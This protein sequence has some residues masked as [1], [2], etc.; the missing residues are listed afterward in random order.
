VS[1]RPT[2]AAAQPGRGEPSIWRWFQDLHLGTK[3]FTVVLVFVFVFSV[4]LGLGMLSMVNLSAATDQAAA[5]QKNVLAPMQNVRVDQVVGQLILRRIAMAPNS[6][7]RDTILGSLTGI[8][9]ALN[10]DIATV[11]AN[12]KD[13]VAKWDQ[14]LAERERYIAYRDATLLPLAR[15]GNTAAVDAAI[16]SAPVMS[17]DARTTLITDAA[18]TIE[19]RINADSAA[20]ASHNA[21]DVGLLLIA[22]VAGVMLAGMLARSV[23]RETSH[24]VLSVMGSVD[25]MSMGDLTV[26]AQVRS[27]DEIGTMAGALNTARESLRAMLAK[28]AETAETMGTAVQELRASNVR[29]AEGSEESTA[30]ALTVASASEQVS[31][32]V[33]D[34]A[35]GAAELTASIRELTRNASEAATFAGLGVT[36]SDSTATTVN[37]LGRSSKQI[38]AF[39]K[40]ITSIAEQTNLLAL[41]ATIE[42]A[43]AGEAGKGFA[44]VAAE[45]KELARESARTAEDIA[46][47]IESNQT[48]TTSAVAAIGE[49]STTIKTINE[50]QTSIANAM[51]EHA[52]TTNE[53]SRSVS[54]AASSASDIAANMAA[55]ASAVATSS[56][57]LGEMSVSVADVARM[58]GDLNDRVGEFTY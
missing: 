12:L 56:E 29:V 32:T 49:I 51:E 45:V 16:A 10:Y 22:F 2:S 54:A 20:A 44:V 43:R 26:P 11:N 3:L 41:N 47:L 33:Q 30:Q 19:N 6:A 48:Q 46:G 39:V 58:A 31:S 15:T 36:F 52:A 14:F 5:T 9:G 1:T 23:I 50:Y 38:A 37:E 8:D 21:R 13:P 17:S 55:V 24:A 18:H 57:V 27:R 28:V 7:L 40:V 42:A 34:V 4:V 53:M 25:A 35:G